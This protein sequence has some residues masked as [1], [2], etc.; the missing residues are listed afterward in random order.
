M[1][2]VL[3]RIRHSTPATARALLVMQGEMMKSG[4]G[5]VGKLW[6]D[7]GNVCNASAYRNGRVGSARSRDLP[8]TLKLSEIA[9]SKCVGS[10]H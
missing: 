1:F 6:T 2:C 8:N 10:S 7:G 3:D 5:Q 9:W 4:S